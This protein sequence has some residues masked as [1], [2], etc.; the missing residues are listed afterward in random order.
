LKN[1]FIKLYFVSLD[2]WTLLLNKRLAIGIVYQ[3]RLTTTLLAIY[4]TMYQLPEN[5][6][7]SQM[8]FERQPIFFYRHEEQ[9]EATWLYHG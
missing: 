3:N 1:D 4:V 8:N 2:C 5:E 9:E 7:K 6:V